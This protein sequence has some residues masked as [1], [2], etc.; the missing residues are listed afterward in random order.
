MCSSE[1]IIGNSRFK[2]CVQKRRTPNQITKSQRKQKSQ[3]FSLK[4]T[5]ELHS[6]ADQFTRPRASGFSELTTRFQCTKII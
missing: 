4:A 6:A 5:A 2:P 1:N 3:L